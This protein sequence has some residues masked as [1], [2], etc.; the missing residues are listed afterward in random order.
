MQ[1]HTH[2]L[3]HKH[4]HK[5]P[6]THTSLGQLFLRA[7]VRCLQLVLGD[8]CRQL[9]APFPPRHLGAPLALPTQ[10][11]VLGRLREGQT[12][13]AGAATSPFFPEKAK[14]RGISRDLQSLWELGRESRDEKHL[15]SPGAE[16]PPLQLA[17]K[18]PAHTTSQPNPMSQEIV[19]KKETPEVP[20][21]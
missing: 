17:L 4:I 14:S 19:R 10:H 11:R 1:I 18:S 21:G 15:G 13:G 8:H 12:Q 16:A 5:T 20:P 6:C 9:L 3:S 7:A 2:S